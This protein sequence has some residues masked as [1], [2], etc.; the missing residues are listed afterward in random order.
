MNER[1]ISSTSVS[2]SVVP[3]VF[4]D[5]GFDGLPPSLDQNGQREPGLAVHPVACLASLVLHAPAALRKNA[6][7]RVGE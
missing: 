5:V 4:L 7:V 2:V 1:M 6:C 3:P